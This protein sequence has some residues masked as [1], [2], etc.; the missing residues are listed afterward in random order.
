[1]SETPAELAVSSVRDALRNAP[2]GELT[3]RYLKAND[4]LLK[5]M[6]EAAPYRVMQAGIEG[7][8]EER[9]RE[10]RGM[11]LPTGNP[12][13]EINMV[14]G[15]A[16]RATVAEALLFEKLSKYAAENKIAQSEITACVDLRFA[17]PEWWSNLT[18]LKALVKKYGD[19]VEK[20]IQ[21]CITR[22]S[23]IPRFTVTI[24]QEERAK[25]SS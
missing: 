3:E 19:A 13:I 25:L 16:P 10:S 11:T 23:A 21:S 20:I 2:M 9:L 1:M 7:I 6:A 18:A 17:E 4:E 8:W 15:H 14:P 5:L 22:H 24:K 12:A